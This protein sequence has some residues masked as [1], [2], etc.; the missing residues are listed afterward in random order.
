MRNDLIH[1]IEVLTQSC[2]QVGDVYYQLPEAKGDRVYR[3]RVYC[4]E[5]YH[6]M[7]CRWG[8]FPYSLGGEVDKAGHAIFRGGPYSR[9]KP[10]FLVHVPG[11]MDGNL[12]VVEVKPSTAT[13]RSMEADVRKLLWFCRE[14][15]SYYCGT[16]LIYGPDGRV[17]DRL[18]RLRLTVEEA[19]ADRFAFIRHT[20]VQEPAAVVAALGI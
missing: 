17:D 15:A 5:L 2:T 10:D 4:Y 19:G 9:S 8:G 7:R 20:S 14:P 13:L 3:E 11:A 12:A 18:Q 1:F 6:Q 16:F